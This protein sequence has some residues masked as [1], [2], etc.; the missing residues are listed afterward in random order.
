MF[1]YKWDKTSLN[2][3]SPRRSLGDIVDKVANSKDELSI[4]IE[5]FNKKIVELK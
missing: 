4:L 5:N 3:P 2:I 1:R